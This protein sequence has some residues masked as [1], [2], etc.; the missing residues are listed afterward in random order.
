MD[1]LL[2]KEAGAFFIT[3][4]LSLCSR[5]YISIAAK[6][7]RTSCS[8]IS[9]APLQVYRSAAP[10]AQPKNEIGSDERQLY[11]FKFLIL[12]FLFRKNASLLS[13]SLTRSAP[14]VENSGAR[15]REV[16]YINK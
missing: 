10:P 1:Y 16:K 12:S 8:L 13:A 15:E 6:A 7:K 2:N 9:H 5:I 4:S 11:F 3:L 14:K